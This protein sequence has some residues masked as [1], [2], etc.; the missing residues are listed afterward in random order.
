MA[1]IQTSRFGTLSYNEEDLLF[2]PRG[3]PGFYTLL[4]WVVSGD[5]DSPVKWLQSVEDPSVALPIT[6]PHMILADYNA[7]VPQQE[8]EELDN[9]LPE[10]ILILVVLTIP[11]EKPWDM[12]ANLKAPIIINTANRKGKQILLDQEEYPIRFYCFPE[13]K[14]AFFAQSAERKAKTVSSEGNCEN[15]PTSSESPLSEGNDS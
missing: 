15:I 4:R 14:R 3:I 2:F 12:T 5:E 7:V 8:L 9:P 11:P 10:E 13:E 1:Q 6:A